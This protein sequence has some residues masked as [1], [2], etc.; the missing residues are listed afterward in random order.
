M[1]GWHEL[2]TETATAPS[3]KPAVLPP[4]SRVIAVDLDPPPTAC[5]VF[6][7]YAVRRATHACD[8]LGTGLADAFHAHGLTVTSGQPARSWARCSKSFTPRKG[9]L[10]S[11][12]QPYLAHR[13]PIAAMAIGCAGLPVGA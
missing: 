1:F 12:H 9:I 5:A 11:A 6:D 10:N 4:G 13:V 3:M 7:R 8:V 2:P